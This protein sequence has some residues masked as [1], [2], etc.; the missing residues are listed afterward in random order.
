M[1]G[2][3]D[4]MT[5]HDRSDSPQ[6]PRGSAGA[7]G[8]GGSAG[9]GGSGGADGSAGAGGSAGPAG[10][11][12]RWHPSGRQL[13]QAVVGLALAVALVVWGLPHFAKTSWDEVFQVL[14]H[15]GWGAA[16]GMLA[17]ML[18]GLWLYTFTLTGS[19]PGLSHGRAL[20]VNVCGSS[21]GN[22]LPGGGAAGVAATYA[23]CRSW[24]FGRRDISTSVIVSGVWNILA[25]VALPVVG[26][27]ALLFGAGGLP[28][29]V[30]R[31]G[32]AGAVVAVLLMALFVS[33]IVSERAATVV[34]RALDRVLRPLWRRSW[35][36]REL[37]IDELVHDLRA[38]ITDV[39]RHGW[40]S[41]TFGLVGL[42]GV[43]YVLFWFCL[44]AV[45]VQMSFGQI[46]AAYAVG[47]LLTAVGVTPGGVGVTE[48]GTAAVLVAWG[49][50]PAAALAGVVLFSVYTHLMEIPLGAIGWLAWGLSRKQRPQDAA[51]ATPPQ[52]ASGPAAPASPPQSRRP[53]AMGSRPPR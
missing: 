1:S 47:R 28:R 46:F 24:G 9:A 52:P 13:L 48:S 12:I 3:G 31:G 29:A 5:A 21:V 15:V 17:L 37:T 39:V 7:G 45:G 6:V 50:P 22:L 19:L 23:L 4:L 11:P 2:G 53:S 38:R 42:F 35:A 18:G 27:V 40:I 10:P 26:V 33:V 49:A 14:H 8:S 25:R 36:G 44:H 41:M 16:G 43:Y 32:L 30:V 20:I 34:G 51:P